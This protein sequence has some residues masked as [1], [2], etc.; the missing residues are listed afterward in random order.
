M[1]KTVSIYLDLARGLAALAV[2]FFHYRTFI[3][4]ASFPVFPWIGHEAVIVFF[5]LSGV[6]IHHSAK[7]KDKNLGMYFGKRFSRLYSVLFPCL[8]LTVV[9]DQTGWHLNPETYSW[10]YNPTHYIKNLCSVILFTNESWGLSVKFSANHVLWSLAYEFWYY[11]IFGL[12]LYI[13]S[14]RV[15]WG[16][17]LL[18]SAVAG[19][20]IVLLLPVWL[21]GV[22]A[23]RWMKH[24]PFSR[25]GGWAISVFS[26]LAVLALWGFKGQYAW[27]VGELGGMPLNYSETF[28]YDYCIGACITLHF[29]AFASICSDRERFFIAHPRLVKALRY[30]AGVSFTLYCCHL[31]I[32]FFLNALIGDP[33]LYLVPLLCVIIVFLFG[34]QIEQTREMYYNIIAALS[35]IPWNPMRK[36]RQAMLTTTGESHLN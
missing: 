30:P 17:V 27:R 34:H 36:L 5:V 20:Q 14:R 10:V 19:P 6:V 21:M 25:G 9:L 3:T 23:Y 31:P 33:V 12:W 24:P 7:T 22:W 26:T 35:R 16:L 1:N 2:V 8:L 13:R 32:M 29:I 4:D 18:A 15:S 11:I 28:L